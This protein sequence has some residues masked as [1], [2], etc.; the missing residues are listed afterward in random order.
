MGIMAT[1]GNLLALPAGCGRSFP[2]D[3]ERPLLAQSA[4]AAH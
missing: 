2:W 4:R 1:A 3:V